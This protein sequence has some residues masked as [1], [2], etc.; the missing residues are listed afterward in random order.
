ML[1]FSSYQFSINFLKSLYKRSKPP[2]SI[3]L[4]GLVPWLS[5]YLLPLCYSIVLPCAWSLS[6][7]CCM[8]V[9][10]HH[11]SLPGSFLPLC[12][13]T[14]VIHQPCSSQFSSSFPNDGSLQS[15][16]WSTLYSSGLP[17]QLRGPCIFHHTSPTSS[18]TPPT[19]VSPVTLNSV[20]LGALW[21]CKHLVLYS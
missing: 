6:S 1:N 5:G 21:E 3:F 8:P 9:T 19:Y 17:A 20:K 7:L 13:C 16:S 15:P 4:P 12:L 11:W 2:V 14:R 18:L 10:Q